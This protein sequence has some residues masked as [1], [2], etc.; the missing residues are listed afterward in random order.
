MEENKFHNTFTAIP[1][2]NGNGTIASCGVLFRIIC[3]E[4]T[5]GTEL[6]YIRTPDKEG[7]KKAK[8]RI[9]KERN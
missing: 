8:K 1:V 7:L 6:W 2:R 9:K 3:N 4:I 5:P